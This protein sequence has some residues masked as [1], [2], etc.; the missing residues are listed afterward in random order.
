MG[1][2]TY[3]FTELELECLISK[4]NTKALEE[5]TQKI[6]FDEKTAEDIKA[7]SQFVDTWRLAKKVGFTHMI[8]LVVTLVCGAVALGFAQLIIKQ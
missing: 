3:N 1:E 2:K 4:A 7:I 6:G 8:K 5:F